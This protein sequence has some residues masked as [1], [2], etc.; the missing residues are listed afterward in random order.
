[1]PTIRSFDDTKLSYDVEGDG[2]VV[3]LLHGYATDGYINWVRPGVVGRLTAAGYRSVNVDQRGHGMS[4]KPHDPAA[5]GDGAMIRDARAVLDEIG[6]DKVAAVGYSMGALNTLRLLTEGEPRI[7]AAVLAGIGA[8]SIKARSGDAIAEAMETEDRS[9]IT[10]PIAKSFREFAELTRADRK[11]LA[12]LQRREP[13]EIAGVDGVDVP[14]LVL[15]GD[16]D[17]MIGDPGALA[18]QMPNARSAVV[19]GSHLNVVNNPQFHGELV[20]FLDEHRLELQ[21]A[22]VS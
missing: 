5:Y 8:D 11:A 16:N 2:P 13:E 14:V 3:L 18:A 17:P 19:G 7:R 20:A 1:M 21:R 15:T 6:A 22:E 12:A 4:D 10:H 9:S